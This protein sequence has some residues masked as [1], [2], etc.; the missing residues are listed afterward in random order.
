MCA[1]QEKRCSGFT[2]SSWGGKSIADTALER[3]SSIPARGGR[4]GSQQRPARA[5]CGAQPRQGASL[6]GETENLLQEKHLRKRSAGTPVP[7]GDM[8]VPSWLR[9]LLAHT[10]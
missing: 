8:G 2:V 5:S 6:P 9:V 10:G 7:G 4:Q 1:R 3:D